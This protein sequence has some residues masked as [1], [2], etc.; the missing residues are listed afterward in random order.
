M[1]F[2]IVV[3][4]PKLPTNHPEL[5]LTKDQTADSKTHMSDNLEHAFDHDFEKMSL[6]A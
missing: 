2:F 3:Q 1:S 4:I 6:T 5:F